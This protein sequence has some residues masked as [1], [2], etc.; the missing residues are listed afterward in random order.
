MKKGFLTFYEN[1]IYYVIRFEF[2]E[3]LESLEVAETTILTKLKQ[4]YIKI[5]VYLDMPLLSPEAI[6]FVDESIVTLEWK[7]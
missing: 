1:S 3:D 7:K 2:G 4:K 6:K 5:C